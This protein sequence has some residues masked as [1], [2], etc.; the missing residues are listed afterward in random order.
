MKWWSGLHLTWYFLSLEQV[1]SLYLDKSVMFL[2][3]YRMSTSFRWWQ[4]FFP[5]FQN[6]QKLHA[7]F[8]CHGVFVSIGSNPKS[9]S[10]EDKLCDQ[11]VCVSWNPDFRLAWLCFFLYIWLTKVCMFRSIKIWRPFLNTMILGLKVASLA[12][13]TICSF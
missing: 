13:T 2:A 5:K 9:L 1:M 6:T 11:N 10:Y 8:F 3:P 4:Q 7:H 12:S